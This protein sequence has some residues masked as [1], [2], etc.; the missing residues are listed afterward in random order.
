MLDSQLRVLRNQLYQPT[1]TTDVS[2]LDPNSKKLFF[3]KEIKGRKREIFIG[4]SRN[5]HTD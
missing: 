4:Q 1:V 3:F 2:F 5:V